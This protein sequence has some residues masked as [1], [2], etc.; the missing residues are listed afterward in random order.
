MF[1]VNVVASY[2]GSEESKVHAGKFY[3]YLKPMVAAFAGLLRSVFCKPEFGAG[4]ELMQQMGT[5]GV[6]CERN[7]VPDCMVGSKVSAT[8]FYVPVSKP[9]YS[10]GKILR[11][12][13]VQHFFYLGSELK[14]SNAHERPFSMQGRGVLVGMKP[15]RE[16]QDHF[17]LT[18]QG[19]QSA[20]PSWMFRVRDLKVGKEKFVQA[21]E[22]LAQATVLV[23][24]SS[25][26]AG[27]LGIH[28][29]IEGD[30]W[31]VCGCRW[32]DKAHR[33]VVNVIPDAVIIANSVKVE[34]GE[35]AR[36]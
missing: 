13:N 29:L 34:K 33:A 28:V 27:S 26:V 21:P 14:T 15:S 20:E 2:E 7:Q 9:F 36:A 25:M 24:R 3:V 23:P 6:T 22:T 1:T 31:P 12:P 16:Y 18:I 10:R 5:L 32:D 11:N 30:L 8:I 35:K 17:Q 19:D 4:Q